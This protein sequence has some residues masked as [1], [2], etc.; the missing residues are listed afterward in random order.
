MINLSNY[1]LQ[2]KKHSFFIREFGIWFFLLRLLNKISFFG[3]FVDYG[4]IRLKERRI[5]ELMPD[6]IKRYLEDY[7]YYVMG[8]RMDIDNPVG[9]N[10]KIQWLKLNDVND[11]KILCSD[12]FEV[13]D[14]ISAK[15]GQV[16]LARIIG[17]YDSPDEIKFDDLPRA[18]VV[19]ATQGSGYNIIVKNKTKRTEKL[20]HR[21]FKWWMKCDFRYNS[22]ENQYD[23]SKNRIIIEEYLGDNIDEYKFMCFN[24]R[25]EFFWI[26]SSEN[27][28]LTRNFYN[29]DRKRIK[30]HF[31]NAPEKKDI[32]FPSTFNKLV[33]DVNKLASEF[34][35]V[36]VDSFVIENN[37]IIGELT[38]TSGA[39]YDN[40]SPREE[41]VRY[42][43]L[44]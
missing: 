29:M 36:R 16:R 39:G 42:G 26:R 12:K 23:I 43:N 6:D 27:G 17:V 37:Y 1:Y 11:K 41:S 8:Y 44:I 38:F 14:Y 18:F 32:I 31:G 28:T 34:R 20:V 15:I 19:K 5:V 13:R 22:Y 24:G 35:F 33:D 10:E 2:F 7:F 40:W 21:A 3:P 9:L 25:A 4:C 30:F